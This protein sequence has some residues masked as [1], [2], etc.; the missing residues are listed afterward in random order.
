MPLSPT[1]TPFRVTWE[2]TDGLYVCDRIELSPEI[3]P[4]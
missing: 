3:D 4:W 2:I 1:R